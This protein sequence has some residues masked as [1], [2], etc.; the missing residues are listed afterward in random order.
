MITKEHLLTVPDLKLTGKAE[1]TN[2]SMFTSYV[3]TVNSFIDG[4]PS[5]ADKIRDAV[6]KKNYPAFSQNVI[7]VF[8]LLEKLHADDIVHEYRALFDKLNKSAKK[9]YD[10]I[11]AFAENLILTVS[12]L[13]IDIQMASKRQPSKTALSVSP[14]RLGGSPL[15]LAVD[16]AI[17]FLNTLK[18]Q[19]Q[20]EPYE[21]YCTTSAD[22]ALLF[23]RENRPAIFLLDIAMPEMDGYELAR[24]IKSSGHNAP[25]IFITAHYEQEYVDMAAEAGAVD[26]LMK[27]V[28]VKQ[29]LTKLRA[30]IR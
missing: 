3:K 11:E 25:I 15:I 14:A 6:D 13:A 23:I 9:D 16:N 5:Y 7:S 20:N 12:S 24:R 27:P 28:R 1:L 30:N 4:F 22:E 19:L 10:E 26:M 21:L 2:S 17:M 18:R 29:L 8:N